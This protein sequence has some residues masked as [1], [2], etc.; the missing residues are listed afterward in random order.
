[1]DDSLVARRAVDELVKTIADDD[2][3]MKSLG[4]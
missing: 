1:L 2:Q 4:N 3:V